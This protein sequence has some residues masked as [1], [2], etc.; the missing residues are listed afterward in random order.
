MTTTKTITITK[1]IETSFEMYDK[2]TSDKMVSA[3]RLDA[4]K[5]GV[6]MSYLDFLPVIVSDHLPDAF[7]R[8]ATI[9]RA[10][11]GDKAAEKAAG[12]E[13]LANAMTFGKFADMDC[14]AAAKAYVAMISKRGTH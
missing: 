5:A 3:L 13:A 4:E 12:F 7:R 8:L 10:V 6:E 9:I 11:Y 14:Y 1:L 2:I